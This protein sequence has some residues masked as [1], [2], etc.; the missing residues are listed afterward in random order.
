MSKLALYKSCMSNDSL[1]EARADLYMRG[2]Y[3]M[4][5]TQDEKYQIMLEALEEL[6][7]HLPNSELV[8]NTLRRVRDE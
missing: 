5:Y 7:K 2:Y 1:S 8:N 3:D 4:K 6:N